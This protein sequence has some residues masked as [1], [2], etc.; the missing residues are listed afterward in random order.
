MSLAELA[1]SKLAFHRLHQPDVFLDLAWQKLSDYNC[2]SHINEQPQLHLN[3]IK[4]LVKQGLKRVVGVGTCFEIAE[5]AG[6]SFLL[7]YPQGKLLLLNQL[8][9]LAAAENINFAWLRPFYVYGLNKNRATLFND[10]QKAIDENLPTF[11][12]NNPNVAHDFLSVEDLGAKIA[13]FAVD[14]NICGIVNCCSGQIQ[15]V[16]QIAQKYAAQQSA[17]LHFEWD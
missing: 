14:S 4:N 15:T 16:A 7:K 17:T 13:E 12:L 8:T 1:N 5:V 10:I 2:N 11:K 3:L 6:E 9:D